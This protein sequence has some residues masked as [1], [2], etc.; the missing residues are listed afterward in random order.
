MTKIQKI[1]D[2]NAFQALLA[3][4]FKGFSITGGLLILAI[5]LLFVVHDA[6]KLIFG[7]F[8]PFPLFAA[9]TRINCLMEGCCF[10]KIWDGPCAVKYPPASHASR[11]HHLKHGLISRF[12][13]SYPV[14]PVQ[15]YLVISMFILFLILFVMNRFKVSRNIIAGSALIGYG[16]INFIIEF[17]RVEPLLYNF[18]TVG[19]FMEIIITALGFYII[20]KVRD[21]EIK[22]I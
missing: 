9:I 21:C 18:L 7:I 16:T 5:I 20:F 6:R 3:A 8:Y 13:V 2:W 4:L 11:L 10:G 14:H 1:N 15:A 19:Q 17:L 12:E 22:D